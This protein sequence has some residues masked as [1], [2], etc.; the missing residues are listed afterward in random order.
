MVEEDLLLKIAIIGGG[1]Y[2]W[3]FGFIR[4][5][6][7]SELLKDVHLTLADIDT[8][9]LDLIAS[10]GER[11]NRE[12]GSPVTLEKTTDLD[13]ALDQDINGVGDVF[14]SVFPT[15]PSCSTTKQCM[16]SVA[17]TSTSSGRHTRT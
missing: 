13:A 15:S 8:A 17:A 10:A 16:T 9:A 11:Y 6:V 3:A 1:S 14:F 5:F 12:A 2:L 4:Q 7:D